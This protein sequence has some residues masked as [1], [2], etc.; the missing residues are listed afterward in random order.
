MSEKTNNAL[1]NDAELKDVSGGL[2]AE[3]IRSA[4][5]EALA[6]EALTQGLTETLTETLT[7]SL[8]STEVLTSAERLAAPAETLTSTAAESIR[9]T[10]TETLTSKARQ[11]L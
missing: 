1:L 6:N 7:E 9:S 2:R 3:S 4:N 10:A 11:I 8:T 5:P